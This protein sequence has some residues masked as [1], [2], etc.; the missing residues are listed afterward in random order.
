MNAEE[1]VEFVLRR[2]LKGVDCV[3]TWHDERAVGRA[4]YELRERLME[5]LPGVELD[6]SELCLV[7]ALARS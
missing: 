3:G 2:W 7:C 6:S 5:E 1:E 4:A